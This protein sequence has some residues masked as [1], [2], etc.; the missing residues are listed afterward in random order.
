VVIDW[1][2]SGTVEAAHV[3]LPSLGYGESEGVY[4]S[5]DGRVQ[6]SRAALKPD[7]E[8]E[9][10]WSVLSELGRRFGFSGGYRSGSQVFDEIAVERPAFAGL[11][12]RHLGLHG[13]VL[14]GG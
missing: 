2:R 6:R 13:A 14:E 11:S 7:R 5:C 10:V 4:V 3:A 12:Y 8:S 1:W 9:P